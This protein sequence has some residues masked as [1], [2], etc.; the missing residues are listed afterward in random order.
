MKAEILYILSG[1]IWVAT[2][3][4]TG[5]WYCLFW[6]VILS[7]LGVILEIANKK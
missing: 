7:V 4:A 1:Q 3:V 6:G 2:Y 5:K